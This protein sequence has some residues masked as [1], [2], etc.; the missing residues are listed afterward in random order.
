MPPEQAADRPPA[1]LS[2]VES[3]R[4]ATTPRGLLEAI[5]CI[6]LANLWLLH[7]WLVLH[8]PGFLAWRKSPLSA[9]TQLRALAAGLLAILAVATG[10]WLLLR[11]LR[12]SGGAVARFIGN[13]GVI[14]VLLV[15]ANAWR[16]IGEFRVPS[17]TRL[18]ALG[19]VT[20]IVA[21][22]ILYNL[23]QRPQTVT[24]G[25]VAVVMCLSP[26]LVIS[27]GKTL[28]NVSHP[29]PASTMADRSFAP[30]V[31]PTSEQR[32]RLVWMIFDELDQRA[33]FTTRPPNV[34]LPEFDRLRS[35]SFH[36]EA[37]DRPAFMTRRAIPSLV[38]G[39]AVRDITNG[40][41]P[42]L[43]LK[44]HDS[45]AFQSW[46]ETPSIFSAARALGLNAAI[47]GWYIP[48]CRTFNEQLSACAWEPALS[49]ISQ[50]I[51]AEVPLLKHTGL[52][53]AKSLYYVPLAV[54]LRIARTS[55]GGYQD[56]RK[57]RENEISEYQSIREKAFSY[58][59][60]RRYDLVFLHWPVPHE[61]GIYDC[62][63]GT[64]TPDQN[65]TY[66]DNLCLAD[67]V[68]GD[69]RTALER[70]KLAESTT[71]LV[72][73]DHSLRNPKE[74]FGAKAPN[75]SFVPFLLKLAGDSTPI[76]F[77]QPF[78]AVLSKDLLLEILRGKL[79]THAEIAA[80]VASNHSRAS[81][82]RDCST[83]YD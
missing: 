55:W 5:F 46:Q 28:W 31:S 80:W 58:L 62:A 7:V 51:P 45:A 11:A 14:F 25:L 71:I 76:R 17:G 42:D 54:R 21:L 22:T 13:A 3:R 48:Y 19:I 56:K 52:L 72:S 60:D 37:V 57:E 77:D 34:P 20:A 69:V 27:A 43:L 23:W 2:G 10:L 82:C 6:S 63:T 26:L 50:E 40:Q 83:V 61:P 1:A 29:I 64:I 9:E 4:A 33:L 16:A 44:F 38:F 24:S 74:V 79:R 75:S 70:E 47:A 41:P 39:R 81:V 59:T 49:Q 67:R 36:G 53:L 73:A 8:S 32:P 66:M 68:L 65:T 78:S 18:I 12:A 30:L 15:A 35:Q